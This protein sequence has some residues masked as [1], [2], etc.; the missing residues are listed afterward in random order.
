MTDGPQGI[1]D[2]ECNPFARPAWIKQCFGLT[3]DRKGELALQFGKT[4][5]EIINGDQNFERYPAFVGVR[6]GFAEIVGDRL[7]KTEKWKNRAS[8]SDRGEPL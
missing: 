4:V 3:D 8:Y 5:D 1:I 7:E 6:W 2:P